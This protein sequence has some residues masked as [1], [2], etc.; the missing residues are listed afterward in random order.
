M[1][2]DQA[3]VEVG[4]ICEREA[5]PRN[6]EMKKDRSRQKKKPKRHMLG[7]GGGKGGGGE[8]KSILRISSRRPRI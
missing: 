8:E 2:V 4:L 5:G 7:G 3:G 1:R 6:C